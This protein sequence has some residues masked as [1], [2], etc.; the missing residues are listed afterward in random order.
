[1]KLCKWCKKPFEPDYSYRKYCCPE[2]AEAEQRRYQ[3]EYKLKNAD[4]IKKK[5]LEYRKKHYKRKISYCKICGVE[6]PCG[7]QQYCLDCLLKDFMK[8]KEESKK[9]HTHLVTAYSRLHCRG[10]DKKT[11]ETEIEKK[12]C[13]NESL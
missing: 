12:G 6:L 13:W 9:A 10:Y 7:K 2:C 4:K 11:I 1:M 3:K 8:A 5:Q